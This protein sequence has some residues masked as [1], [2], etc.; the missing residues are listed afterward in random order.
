MT[1]ET[2]HVW[3]KSADGELVR[4]DAIT[5][6]RCRSGQVE[7]A[8]PDGT[9]VRLAGPGCPTAFHVALLREMESHW[10]WPDARWVVIISG[11][12]SAD[13]APAGEHAAR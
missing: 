1:S 10:R 5:W 7:T 8:R 2:A 4:S 13:G 11:E 9:A 12:V 3:I 6:L